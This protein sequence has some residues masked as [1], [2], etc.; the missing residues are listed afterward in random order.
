MSTIKKQLEEIRQTLDAHTREEMV[1]ILTYLF[2]EYVMEGS[3]PL[4]SGAG[5]VLNTQTEFDKASF[6]EIVTW[7][8]HHV[9][10]P[11][12]GLFE[13]Q[14]GRVSIR[15]GGRLQ[16]IEPPRPEP[17]PEVVPVAP[18]PPVATP[19]APTPAPAAAAP[20]PGLPSNPLQPTAPTAAPTS[21]ASSPSSSNDDSN[22]SSESRFSRLD[23]D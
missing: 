2:K 14:N 22:Y 6:G 23:V 15:L 19:A 8:Q 16:T 17:I 18:A 12:L 11:E 4:G 10:V 20:L 1:E 9:D 13:V 3:S 21:P 5:M 7:L